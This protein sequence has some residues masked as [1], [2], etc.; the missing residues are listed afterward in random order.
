VR[1]HQECARQRARIVLRGRRLP[2][3][4]LLG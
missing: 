2:E 4:F 1:K 3:Q